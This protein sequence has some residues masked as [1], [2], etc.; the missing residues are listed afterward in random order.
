[1]GFQGW[2]IRGSYDHDPGM[3]YNASGDLIFLVRTDG[4]VPRGPCGPEKLELILTHYCQQAWVDRNF[5]KDERSEIVIFQSDNVLT[6]HALKEV[7][8]ENINLQTNLL[9]SDAA[10][11]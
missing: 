9:S 10:S 6:P 5:K 4:H 3:I 2:F 7:I 1:M 8:Q 11:A